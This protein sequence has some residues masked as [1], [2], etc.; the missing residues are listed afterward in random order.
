MKRRYRLGGAFVLLVLLIIL[1]FFLVRFL[2]HRHLYAVTNAVFVETEA[3]V[4]LSFDKVNGRLVE[5]AKEEGEDVS[6]GEILARLDPT[7]YVQRVKKLKASVETLRHKAQAL[8]IEIPRLRRELSL[9]EAQARSRLERLTAE[10]EAAQREWW[11]LKAKLTQAQR[12]LVRFKRLFEKELI[13]KRRLEETE[14]KTRFLLEREEALRLRV[15]GLSAGIKEAQKEIKLIANQRKLILEKKKELAALESE[16]KAQEEALAE[17]QTLL[18]FCRLSS[19][20]QGYVAKRFHALGDVVGPGEPVYAIADFSKLYILVLL[21]ENKLHG[22]RPGCKAKIKIDAFPHEDFK[23]EVYQVLPA[24]AAKFAL[25][26][27][28]I[29]AGE[30]TKVAQRVPVKIRITKGPVELLRVGLGGEV[31]IKRSR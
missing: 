19:P 8:K 1:F 2:W 20:I 15:K 11:A 29:S 14:T 23:G 30:F 12:D 4:F 17:A 25:V 6:P 7:I 24:T 28:D 13:P 18:G 5:L 21:E 31:E 22:V 16:I 9:K 10:K 26:P 27:R 3:L